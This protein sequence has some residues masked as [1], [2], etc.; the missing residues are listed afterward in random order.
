MDC[1]EGGWRERNCS[2][3]LSLPR[4]L[5]TSFLARLWL[6]MPSGVELLQG[7]FS[8]GSG[9]SKHFGSFPVVEFSML[10]FAFISFQ[11]CN[12]EKK[13]GVGLE[14]CVRCLR[15]DFGCIR[16]TKLNLPVLVLCS[17]CVRSFI[18][19][20]FHFLVFYLYVFGSGGRMN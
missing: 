11:L 6:D 16:G 3:Q 2:K 19:V 15:H 20:G 5:R 7:Q 14:G 10:S 4:K 1:T 8:G 9:V 17:S 12:F 18:L 13:V